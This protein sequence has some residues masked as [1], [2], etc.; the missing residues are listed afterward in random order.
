[1]YLSTGTSAYNGIAI[2]VTEDAA[3]GATYDTVVTAQGS[4]A[5]GSAGNYCQ[6]TGSVILD[7]TDTA[8]IKMYMATGFNNAA[9]VCKGYTE[10]NVTGMN[11]V[12]LGDT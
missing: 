6:V 5:D 9:V 1:M 10:E 12:R 11:F 7:V 3:G 8:N 4:F 2:K